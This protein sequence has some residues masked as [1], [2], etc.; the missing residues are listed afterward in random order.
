MKLNTFERLLGNLQTFTCPVDPDHHTEMDDSPSF[1]YT[2][3][4]MYHSLIGRVQWAITRGW[5]DYGSSML[6][7]YNMV[8]REG[9]L[10]AMKKLFKYLKG[11]T[12][13]KKSLIQ[14]RRMSHI[15]HLS[16]PP[17]GKKSTVM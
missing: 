10:I 4:S 5:I 9:H 6:S 8:P 17:F 2:D 13:E 3:K 11:H 14:E 7:Q 15:Q 16:I 1:G 12:Q